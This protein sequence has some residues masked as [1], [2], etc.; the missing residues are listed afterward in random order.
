MNSESEFI[1]WHLLACDNCSTGILALQ[2]LNGQAGGLS[3]EEANATQLSNGKHVVLLRCA[4]H[5]GNLFLQDYCREWNV[6][7][8]I[9]TIASQF[10]IRAVMC[11]TRWTSCLRAAN[12]IRQRVPPGSNLATDIEIVRLVTKYI[13]LIEGDNADA[14][15]LFVQMNALK[16]ALREMNNTRSK[17]MLGFIET[18]E[19][20]YHTTHDKLGQFLL[21]LDPKNPD[22]DYDS[23]RICCNTIGSKFSRPIPS[24]TALYQE[25]ISIDLAQEADA[26]LKTSPNGKTDYINYLS[27]VWHKNPVIRD[28]L[29]I[30]RALTI[31]SAS[32][33]RLFSFFHR[34][35]ASFLR[36]NM[37]Y[38]TLIKIGLIYTEIILPE[39]KKWKQQQLINKFV[40]KRKRMTLE[41]ELDALNEV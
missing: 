29:S 10:K 1:Y 41:D 20:E 23:F 32:L 33:E 35:T 18:R 12:K 21:N 5:V 34:T 22:I 25:L 37:Q 31:N 13:Q 16:A 27:N 26:Y 36:K 9:H 8:Q 6:W 2:M 3:F 17:S 28:I 40:E 19:T 24:T 38:Q 11:P 39:V 14:Y 4:A 15:V 30:V 7:G